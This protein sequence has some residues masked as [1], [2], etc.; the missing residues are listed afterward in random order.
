MFGRVLGFKSKI[1]PV[2]SIIILTGCP[3]FNHFNQLNGRGSLLLMY[4]NFQRNVFTQQCISRGKVIRVNLIKKL[5][6]I[7]RLFLKERV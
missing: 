4:G 6:I 3:F 5:T 1:S 7:G 2:S